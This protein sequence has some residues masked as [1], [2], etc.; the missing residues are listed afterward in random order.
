MVKSGDFGIQIANVYNGDI[1]DISKPGIHLLVD[2]YTIVPSLEFLYRYPITG[3]GVLSLSNV[4][5][6][7]GNDYLSF[8]EATPWISFSDAQKLKKTP[9]NFMQVLNLYPQ[10]NFF[11]QIEYETITCAMNR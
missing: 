3:W 2:A 4:P 8:L 7:E 10:N 11:W 9:L 6:L 1:M 5:L